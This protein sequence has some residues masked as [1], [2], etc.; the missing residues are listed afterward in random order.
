M[1][2]TARK[3]IK[4]KNILL[5]SLPSVWVKNAGIKPG[6]KIRCVVNDKGQ[7]VLEREVSDAPILIAH[8]VNR[9]LPPGGA[10]VMVDP[11]DDQEQ[12]EV[13]VDESETSGE[14]LMRKAFLG[15]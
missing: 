14:E 12:E 13:P 8:P 1:E 10:M 11:V 5:I 6:E 3:V 2:L 4:G 9:G 7:L 15:K